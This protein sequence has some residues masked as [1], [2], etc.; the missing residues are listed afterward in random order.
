[1][2]SLQM[3]KPNSLFKFKHKSVSL[4][5]SFLYIM[6]QKQ[7]LYSEFRKKTQSQRAEL[8]YYLHMFRLN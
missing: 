2:T 5:F 7:F 8:W 6:D 3:F 1:M 4:Y